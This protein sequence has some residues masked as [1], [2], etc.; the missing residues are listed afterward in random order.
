MDKIYLAKLYDRHSD[1]TFTAF[2]KLDDAIAQCEKWAEEYGDRYEWNIPTWNW[3]QHW[4][5][6]K[7]AGDD[8]PIVSVEEI[9]LH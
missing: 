9:E 3:Q 7:D 6:Y 4:N 5:F 8:G 1:D 2:I